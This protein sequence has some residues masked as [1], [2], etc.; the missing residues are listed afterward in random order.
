MNFKNDNDKWNY[1]QFEANLYFSYLISCSKRMSNNLFEQ[2]KKN[3][4]KAQK[5][6]VMTHL[7]HDYGLK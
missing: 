4:S 1:K 7:V 5:Y 3:I 2:R 6:L